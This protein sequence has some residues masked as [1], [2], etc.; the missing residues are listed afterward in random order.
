MADITGTITIT[1]KKGN[2]IIL[3]IDEAL[4]LV[5]DIQTKL[6]KEKAVYIGPFISP[7]GWLY[8]GTRG[9]YINDPKSY[10]E[11]FITYCLEE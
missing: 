5:E 7:I 6:V 8:D 11:P 10:S 2:S 9:P 4:D 1:D 3:D